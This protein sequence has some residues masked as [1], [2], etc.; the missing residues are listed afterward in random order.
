MATETENIAAENVISLRADPYSY[1]NLLMYH[2]SLSLVE[3][4]V[5][6]GHLTMADY[7]KSVKILSKKYGFPKDSIFAEIA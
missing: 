1:E 6:D 4:M 5:R 3:R 2:T 7:K